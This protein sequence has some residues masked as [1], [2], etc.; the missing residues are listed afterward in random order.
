[1]ALL[2]TCEADEYQAEYS[3]LVVRSNPWEGDLQ[4]ELAHLNLDLLD[5]GAFA[6]WPK[7]DLAGAGNGWVLG[8]TADRSQVVLETHNTPP[9][10]SRD[11]DG[12]RWEDVMETPFL[13]AGRGVVL[14]QVLG[15]YSPQRMKLGSP[16]LYRVRISRRPLEDRSRW[17]LQFWP[18]SAAP[19][20]PRRLSRRRPAAGPPGEQ[21][22]Q[23]DQ[24]F[25]ALAM[26][27]VA[28][29][30]WSPGDNTKADLAERLLAS[31]EEIDAA[32]RYAMRYELLHVDGDAST[33]SMAPVDRRP[34]EVRNPQDTWRRRSAG[35]WAEQNGIKINE[36]GR[37]SP[38]VIAKFRPGGGSAG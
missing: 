24:A 15:D 32:L 8:T 13:T 19:E 27:L 6:G 37:I 11:G 5:E 26:D 2:H 34:P 9:P 16:G 18:V 21:P 12:D 30:L 31:V 10:F 1:V 17:L 38:E 20:P 7:G 22:E 28:V 3:T 14:T 36:P 23:P 25:S 29:G 4:A 33:V 35:A